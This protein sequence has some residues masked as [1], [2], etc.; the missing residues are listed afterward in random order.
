MLL[1][2]VQVEG[3][4]V[5]SGK[6]SGF[7]VRSDELGDKPLV[8]AAKEGRIAIGYGLPATLSGLLSEAGKGK[9]LSD[10]PAYS[11]AVA[12]LGDTPISGFADGPAALRLADSLIPSSDDGFEEAKKYLKSIRF[13]ALGSGTQGDL[14]TA[15]LIVG[16]K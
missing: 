4:T 5:L 1:R 9:T 16:L 3:V 7:S 6:Y 14:A 15:K 2:S 13:L 12:S 11:D 8:V 10:D